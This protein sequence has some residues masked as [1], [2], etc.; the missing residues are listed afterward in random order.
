ME[1]KTLCLKSCKDERRTSI[2]GGDIKYI[3]YLKDIQLIQQHM[4]IKGAAYTQSILYKKLY[5]LDI[6]GSCPAVKIIV[7]TKLEVL[8]WL[9]SL[10]GYACNGT[11]RMMK[12]KSEYKDIFTDYISLVGVRKIIIANDIDRITPDNMLAL[13]KN[14]GI[15]LIDVFNIAN[16][17][18]IPS[19]GFP[20]C[21]YG[22]ITED[23]AAKFIH[24]L[25]PYVVFCVIHMDSKVLDKYPYISQII[26]PKRPFIYIDIHNVSRQK[27]KGKT[28][29]GD[30]EEFYNDL[31]ED[32]EVTNI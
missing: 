22:K 29:T 7:D 25:L 23:N 28:C 30:I 21:I 26:V 5:N 31:T 16:I 12:Y 9:A 19:E 17:E 18:N 2:V 6:D 1:S 32:Q 14:R 15:Q 4:I 10:I 27:Y 8:E 20:I 11:G 24:S 3:L 13:A